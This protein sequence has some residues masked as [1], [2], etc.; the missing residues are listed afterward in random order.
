MERLILTDH[1]EDAVKEAQKL[2]KTGPQLFNV[3][4]SCQLWYL[5]EFL[6]NVGKFF[7]RLVLK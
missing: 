2:Y 7:A 4:G 1:L 3:S 6:K 5:Q